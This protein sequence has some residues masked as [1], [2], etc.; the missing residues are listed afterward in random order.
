MF[1][2]DSSIQFQQFDEKADPS[3]VKPR[4][5]HLRA[6]MESANVD[7][8]LIPRDDA[9]RGEN[10]PAGDERL[11]YMTGFTGSA[12]Y[13]IVTKDRAALVVDGR[14]TIQ[15]P[16]QTDT[17][18]VECVE[19]KPDA[20][21]KWLVD[22]LPTNA[23]VGFDGWLHT[24][25]AI[26]TL[27]DALKKSDIELVE[28]TNLVDE[29]WQDRPAPPTDK[30]FTLSLE[31][32]G[33]SAADKISDLAKTIAERNAD[34]LVLTLPESFCWLF[35]IRGSDIPNTPVTLGFAIIEKSGTAKLYV[36][37]EKITSVLSAELGDAVTLCPISTLESDLKGLAGNKT[38]WMDGNTCPSKL[39]N[40]VIEANG[41]LL[42][43]ADPVLAIKS[44]KNATEI[45]GMVSAQRTDA[46]AMAKFLSWLDAEAPKGELTEIAIVKQLEQIRRQANSL[47]DIS[48][49]TIS[50]S[51]PNGAICHY[52]VTDK[53]DRTLVPG[54]LMLVDSG[55]QYLEGTTDIT[56]TMATGPATSEQK[57]HFTLVLQG[58]I[59][60]SV[61]IFPKGTT[62]THLDVL[63]RQ[64]LWAEGLDYN[65]GTGHGVG[66][67]LGVHEGPCGV[68]P[69]NHSP[70]EV[71]NIISNEPGYYLEGS[72]GIRIE[73]LLV[74]KESDKSTE[75]APFLSFETITFTPIDKRLINKDLMSA[76]EIAWLNHYHKQCFEI[77]AS[78][79]GDSDKAWLH[80]AT[81][82]I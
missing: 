22:A 12:G 7:A 41:E 32:T 16:A 11:A 56:R 66:A 38:I 17:D 28:C 25:Y 9:H 6:A 54:E 61:A 64:F 31:Q 57:K 47:V 62:G 80:Q 69:R 13:A 29:I 40:I 72:H 52:R 65:H 3:L 58:M 21:Q 36:Q 82:P 5:A 73:N 27:R 78:Q 81:Q 34:A 49:E 4:L 79:L 30:I 50:G 33:K 10:V 35:N 55:G 48:F 24:P 67:F 39:S 23:R 1:N 26:K 42:N 18:A 59:A 43:E 68:S 60:L 74:V 63:A 51:G 53:S 15:A 14:Y 44:R 20:A 45:E 2:N 19:M 71:G 76:S 37:P 46:A 70:L 8:F 77:A 75:N